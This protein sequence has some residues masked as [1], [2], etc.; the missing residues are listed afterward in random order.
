VSL[1]ATVVIFC[2]PHGAASG[3]F[4]QLEGALSA[5]VAAVAALVEDKSFVGLFRM[6]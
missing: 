3:V 1:P 6:N 2:R 4:A 5:R